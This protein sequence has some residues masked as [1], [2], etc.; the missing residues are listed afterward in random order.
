MKSIPG[1]E[2]GKQRARVRHDD[3]SGWDIKWLTFLEKEIE[4]QCNSSA[5]GALFIINHG[6]KM[7][8]DKFK[9]LKLYNHFITHILLLLIQP[10]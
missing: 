8:L 1:T 4:K 9:R 3:Y 10:Q 2:A 6:C 7:S 5:H